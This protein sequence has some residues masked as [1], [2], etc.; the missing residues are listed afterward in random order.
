LTD[1][2]AGNPHPEDSQ[3][4]INDLHVLVAVDDAFTPDGVEIGERLFRDS[5]LGG[6]SAL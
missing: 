6:F 2:P 4:Q 5:L 1:R 3:R